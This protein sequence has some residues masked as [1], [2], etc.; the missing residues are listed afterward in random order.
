M[1]A[2]SKLFQR[3]IWLVDTIYSA[4]H[5]SRDE[6]DHRWCSARYNE[7]SQR[8]RLAFLTDEHVCY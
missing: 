4:G 3:L 5:I 8:S 7:R 6:I 1:A 2:Q